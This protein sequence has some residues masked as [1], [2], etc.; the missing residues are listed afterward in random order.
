MAGRTRRSGRVVEMLVASRID[1]YNVAGGMVAW[2]G[3]GLLVVT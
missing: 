1:A 3:A 2:H